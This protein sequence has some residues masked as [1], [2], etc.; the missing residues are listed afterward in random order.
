MLG[1]TNVAQ[2]PKSGI[3]WTTCHHINAIDN[4]TG[5]TYL[6]TLTVEIEYHRMFS[7]AVCLNE[8]K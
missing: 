4:N 8:L 3:L 1:K 6:V 5:C 7:N 2:P